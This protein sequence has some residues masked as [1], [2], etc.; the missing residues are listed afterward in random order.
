MKII[1]YD[2]RY[3][4]SFIELNIVWITTLFGFLEKD[5]IDTFANI[6]KDIAKGAMIYFA[7]END[8]VMAACMIKK[9]D[10]KTWEICKLAADD[11][12]KGRGA[13]N[14]VF[15]KCMEHAITHGAKRL[16]MVSN[17]KLKSALHIYLKHGFKEIKLNNYEYE[18]GDIAFE[19]IVNR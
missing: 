7:I 9:V 2:S 12:Y 6:E 5:D 11:R 13:G 1:Q 8:E 19:Y 3:K 16:F 15:E 14:A 18:R 10:G 4:Q 17:R